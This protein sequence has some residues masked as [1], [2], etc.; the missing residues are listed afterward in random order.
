MADPLE[1]TEK[2]LSTLLEG[3][4]ALE[5]APPAVSRNLSLVLYGAAVPLDPPEDDPEAAPEFRQLVMANDRRGSLFDKV[6]AF[7]ASEDGRLW[8]CIASEDVHW[9]VVN[10]E[11]KG[12]LGAGRPY[13]SPDGSAYACTQT[14]REEDSSYP[15]TRV[16]VGEQPGPAFQTVEPAGF[17]AR[18]VFAYMAYD[19]G[20]FGVVVGG[21]PMGPYGEVAE[22]QWSPDGGHLAFIAGE[23]NQM[24][25]AV[26]LDTRKHPNF[27]DVR[28]LRFS[29][30]SSRLAYVA[31]DKDGDRVIVDGKAGASFG[32][33]M[34]VVWSRD[35][36][37]F[38]SRVGVEQGWAVAVNDRPGAVYDEVG[39]P[40]CNADAG[41]IVYGARR[42]DRSVV[43]VG[44]A[45]SEA[46]DHV[47][48]IAVGERAGVAYALLRAKGCTL[49]HNGREVY[50]AGPRP[51]HLVISPDGSSIAYSEGTAGKVRITVDGEPGESFTSVDRLTFAPDGRTPVYFATQGD[52]SFVVVGHKKHGP[53]VP[54]CDPVFSPS[55]NQLALVAKIDREIWR[56]ILPV[57]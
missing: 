47:Y 12:Q 55:G 8:A 9:L 50:R 39:P 52:R 48:R 35:G 41:T 32:R 31:T 40:V 5:D 30:D 26:V 28:G 22:L 42:G 44:S 11:K 19:E 34:P 57:G 38:L 36:R 3:L 2:R 17:S 25:R 49:V 37:T 51:N 27:L 4:I 53:M 20:Q 14:V 54:W 21:E 16:V 29:P 15:K 33:C 43:V 56:K 45:E 46:C 1:F 13:V 6:G 18:G 23:P 10:H 24:E 7:V